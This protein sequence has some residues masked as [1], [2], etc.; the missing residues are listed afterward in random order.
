MM[1]TTTF[2]GEYA[3]ARILRCVTCALPAKASRSRRGMLK[4]PF[5]FIVVGLLLG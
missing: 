4:R 1:D 2:S 5:D 3:V